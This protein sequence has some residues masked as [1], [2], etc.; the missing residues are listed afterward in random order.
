MYGFDTKR[1]STRCKR[2]DVSFWYDL[3]CK[4]VKRDQLSFPY[5]IWKTGLKICWIDLNVFDNPW[6][7]SGMHINR[8][9]RKKV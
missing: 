2:Y 9:Q 8:K 1:K 7:F 3:L 6:F 4:Y 5:S